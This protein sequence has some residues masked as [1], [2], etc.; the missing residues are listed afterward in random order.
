MRSRSRKMK[1]HLLR[2]QNFPTEPGATRPNIQGAP[3]ARWGCRDYD[4]SGAIWGSGPGAQQLGWP[5]GRLGLLHFG[6]EGPV[7]FPSCRHCVRDLARVVSPQKQA[8]GHESFPETSLLWGAVHQAV[9]AP[10][11][12]QPV[13]HGAGRLGFQLQ[14]G[15]RGKGPPA[16]PLTVLP[17]EVGAGPPG[18]P[19][20]I[21]AGLCQSTYRVQLEAG[22]T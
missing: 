7:L 5:K 21:R 20:S 18:G 17:V 14:L 4:R 1:V 15:R 16:T 10:P 6:E 9:E 8:F 19:P 3:E 2:A 22:V 13:G 11:A 12:T